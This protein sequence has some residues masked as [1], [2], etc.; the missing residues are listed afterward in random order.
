MRVVSVSGLVAYPTYVG[1]LMWN[2]EFL[3][4]TAAKIMNDLLFKLSSQQDISKSFGY[5]MNVNFMQTLK[6]LAYAKRYPI[7]K[8]SIDFHMA[9]LMICKVSHFDEL[10]KMR[11]KSARKSV[12]DV[13]LSKNNKLLKNFKSILKYIRTC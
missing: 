7:Q 12:E 10:L 2:N 9:T 11:Q 8:N 5:L 3:K 4:G 13:I 6:T 1:R